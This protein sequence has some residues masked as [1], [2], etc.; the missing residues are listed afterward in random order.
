MNC[1]NCGWP[2]AAHCTTH[3]IPCCPGRCPGP[4]R[5][6][7]DPGSAVTAYC[8]PGLKNYATSLL[9]HRGEVVREVA[10]HPWMAGRTD[11][12]L[13]ADPDWPIT[14]PVELNGDWP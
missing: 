2:T 13:A 1:S 11:I 10:E 5:P 14:F 8:A 6:L 7:I 4:R 3:L 9:E 12:I